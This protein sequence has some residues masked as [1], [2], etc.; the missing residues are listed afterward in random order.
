MGKRAR[1]EGAI[2]KVD[3]HQAPP[4]QGQ[5]R[6]SRS[7][8][9]RQSPGVAAVR[10]YQ[11]PSFPLRVCDALVQNLVRARGRRKGEQPGQHQSDNKRRSDPNDPPTLTRPRVK[12]PPPTG[13]G[14]DGARGSRYKHEGLRERTPPH[15]DVSDA[16][17]QL[18]PLSKRAVRVS[19][20]ARG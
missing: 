12:T 15:R 11:P 6:P 14:S 4:I 1:K 20:A 9:D 10:A 8:E 13:G 7:A 16:A 5:I 2:G 17:A 3:E 19:G 18:G